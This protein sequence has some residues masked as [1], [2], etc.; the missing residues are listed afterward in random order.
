MHHHLSSFLKTYMQAQGLTLRE[1]EQRS[2]VSRSL[3]H[4]IINSQEHEP[5][6]STLQ[7]IARGTEVPLWRIIEMTGVNLELDDRPSEEAERI[8]HTATVLAKVRQI[9]Q[10]VIDTDDEII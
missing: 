2:Q 3:L 9:W 1:M 10:H 6:L 4:S 7:G 8:A 5:R